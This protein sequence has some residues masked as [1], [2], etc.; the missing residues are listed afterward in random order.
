MIRRAQTH[1]IVIRPMSV[2]SFVSR[3]DIFVKSCCFSSPPLPTLAIIII[4][5]IIISFRINR[6][7]SDK[8]A[9]ILA[10]SSSSTTTRWKVVRTVIYLYT[11]YYHFSKM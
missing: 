3:Y 8:A 11:G 10:T 5:I 4:I 6:I 1:L 9:T 7:S 2:A